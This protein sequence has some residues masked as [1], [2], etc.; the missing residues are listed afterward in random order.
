[1]PQS[2]ADCFTVLG[3]RGVLPPDFVTTARQMAQFRNQLVHL[4]WEV[5]DEAVCSLLHAHSP[6]LTASRLISWPFWNGKR[7]VQRRAK[8]NS[9]VNDER[10]DQRLQIW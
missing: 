4:Y 7:P 3:E 1:M 8:A 5:S 9:E 6:I 10:T 2:Y